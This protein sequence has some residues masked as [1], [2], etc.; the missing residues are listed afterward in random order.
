MCGTHH[1]Y[2]GSY[3][4]GKLDA[5]FPRDNIVGPSIDFNLRVEGWIAAS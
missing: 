4:L 3:I 2:W 1:S 5:D